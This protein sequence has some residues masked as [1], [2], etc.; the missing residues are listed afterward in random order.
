[1]RK[2]S[3]RGIAAPSHKIVR[4]RLTTATQAADEL[5]VVVD[6]LCGDAGNDWLSGGDSN[7]KL[8]GGEGDDLLKGGLGDDLLDGGAGTNWLDGD[9]GKNHLIHGVQAELIDRL[10]AT[11]TDGALVSGEAVYAQQSTDLGLETFL[12]IT[13]QGA[14]PGLD[15]IVSW[16]SLVLGHILI[17][18]E[19]SGELRLSSL[20]TEESGLHLPDLFLPVPGDSL[21]FVDSLDLT[22]TVIISGVFVS[23]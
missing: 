19:G 20:A 10:V 18:A 4:L 21:T 17:G 22:A 12:H 3:P 11:L 1:M 14:T 8:H 15:L 6:D 5:V 16:G 9:E 23:A 2:V 13:V 7:D